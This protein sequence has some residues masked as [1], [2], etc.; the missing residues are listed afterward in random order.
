MR[1]ESGPKDRTGRRRRR[2]QCS[3]RAVAGAAIEVH[4]ARRCRFVTR[5]ARSAVPVRVVPEMKRRGALL[6]PAICPVGRPRGL[7][8]HGKQDEHEQDFFHATILAWHAARARHHKT[9]NAGA[10]MRTCA[11]GCRRRH[12]QHIRFPAS[13]QSCYGARVKKYLLILLMLILPVQYS[14][15]A[16]AVYCQHEQ[17]SP[18]HFGHHAH[19]HKVKAENGGS[20]GKVGKVG[21]ADTDCEYCHLFSH[22]FFIP[23]D[24]PPA[25]PPAVRFA[26]PEPV[27][28]TS[29]IPQRPSRPNWP[30]AA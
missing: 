13:Q 2:C 15:S 11:M 30:L 17:G 19:E 3:D 14:W 22:A 18:F 6:M 16:A 8:C 10:I 28:Y 4:L 26:A 9:G 27:P 12:P 25:G 21:M 24:A 1:V 7:E 23:F 20:H 29:H 5:I